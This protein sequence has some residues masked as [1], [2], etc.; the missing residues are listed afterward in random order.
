MLRCTS[1]DWIR[2]RGINIFRTGSHWG[3]PPA[4]DLATRT[5]LQR[6]GVRNLSGEH[7]L[8]SWRNTRMSTLSSWWENIKRTRRPYRQRLVEN[9]RQ[10]IS[11]ARKMMMTRTNTRN[12]RPPRHLEM[13]INLQQLIFSQRWLQD[14]ERGLA[15]NCLTL[16]RSKYHQNWPQ[17]GTKS[18]HSQRTRKIEITTP[19]VGLHFYVQC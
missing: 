4:P 10:N 15:A 1:Q 16:N 3:S 18:K 6:R 14:Q 7:W 2:P 13:Q 11:Q 5:F 19:W 8:R 17:S 12:T 9:I